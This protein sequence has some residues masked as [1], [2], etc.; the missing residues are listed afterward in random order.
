MMN[1]IFYFLNVM[2]SAGQS[3]LGKLYA[4]RGGASLPFN[5]NKAAIGTLLFLVLGLINGFSLHLHTALF[6]IGYG[7]FLCIS[8]HTGFKALSMG[9]MALTSILASFSLIIPFL[10]GILF[11]NEAL[12]LF[13]ILGILLLLLSILFINLK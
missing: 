11:W 5:I 4:R 3:T 6:G 12:T 9:P 13:K 1:L 2:C 10:F 7:I 8:M